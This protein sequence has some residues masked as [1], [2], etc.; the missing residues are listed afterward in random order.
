MNYMELDM[1]KIVRKNRYYLLKTSDSKY[2]LM[3]KW[4]N[5]EKAN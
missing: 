5:I 3:K 2:N 1:D 4:G